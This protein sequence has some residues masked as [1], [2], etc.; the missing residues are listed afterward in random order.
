M[1]AKINGSCGS[2]P[3]HM[4]FVDLWRKQFPSPRMQ[5]NMIYIF[6]QIYNWIAYTR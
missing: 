5:K 6:I 2:G 1:E 4:R 3:A